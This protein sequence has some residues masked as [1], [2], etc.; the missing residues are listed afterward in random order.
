MV[1]LHALSEYLIKKP[2]PEDL[3]LDVDVRIRGR[4]EI[5][6]H[7]DPS[8]AYA[9]RSS[10]VS[11]RAGGAQ[12]PSV[13]RHEGSLFTYLLYVYSCLLILIWKWRLEGTVRV[14]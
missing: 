10:R 8:T 2:P 4:K 12:S 6:Y 3:R 13:C 9:A 14:Y 5:R 7:F 1:V 11:G